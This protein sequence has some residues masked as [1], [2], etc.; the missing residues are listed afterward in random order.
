MG[1]QESNPANPY[2]SEIV[3]NN[4]NEYANQ[5]YASSL[6]TN[7]DPTL[8]P[9]IDLDNEEPPV[10]KIYKPPFGGIWSIQ[11]PKSLSPVCLTHHFR[12]YSSK[13]QKLFIGYGVENDVKNNFL[14]TIWEFDLSTRKWNKLPLKN[15]QSTTIITKRKNSVATISESTNTMYIYGGTDE[16]NNFLTDLHSVDLLTG[17]MNLI[18]DGTIT[19]PQYTQ[20]NNNTISSTPPQPRKG[21]IVQFFNNR[22]YI[23]GG[24]SLDKS[25]SNDLSVYDI[26]SNTWATLSF[27]SSENSIA[28]RHHIPYQLVDNHLY[29]YGASSTKLLLDIELNE[30]EVQNAFEA[31]KLVNIREIECIG[32]AP[33]ENLYSAGMVYFDS[34]INSEISL[35]G[36][37]QEKKQTG[38]IVYFGGKSASNFSLI[39]GLDLSKFWW[40]V[41]HVAPDGDSVTYVDGKV[42]DN[43]LFMIPRIFN[44]AVG[45]DISKR[46]IVA[47]AAQQKSL[48]ESSKGSNLSMK[49]PPRQNN[50]RKRRNTDE[51]NDKQQSNSFA[52]KNDQQYNKFHQQFSNVL[53]KASKLHTESDITSLALPRPPTKTHESSSFLPANSDGNVTYYDGNNSNNIRLSAEPSGF[54]A[55]NPGEKIFVVSMINVLAGLSIKEDMLNM[56]RFYYSESETPSI[57]TNQ[58]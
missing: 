51:M 11:L 48:T 5:Q 35:V 34:P 49:L 10:S 6:P 18:T 25:I 22:I 39:Y 33:P 36:T 2:F 1:N 21:Q 46:E 40:F 17:E 52:S 37:I 24:Q 7:Y 16:N 38:F 19:K 30:P 23:W 4:G 45:Y 12:T 8:S 31:I 20:F 53:K 55:L 50:Y 3:A 27:S 56:L 44:C 47:C 42:S 57:S 13:M 41:L 9:M 26:P 28:G 43:G 29:A 15:P 58:Q 54:S 14:T 32:A